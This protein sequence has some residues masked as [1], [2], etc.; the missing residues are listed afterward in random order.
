MLEP[1]L[2]TLA[3]H[4]PLDPPQPPRVEHPSRSAPSAAVSFLKCVIRH[5][6]HGNPRAENPVSSASGLFQFI[7]GTWRHYAARVPSARR[8]GHA[9]SAP[10]RVQWEVALL[11]I[12]WHGHRNWAGTSCGYGT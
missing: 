10:A 2:M 3:L 8:Y 5:E 1:L 7:D 12:R 9:A 11:A 6:S 4:A